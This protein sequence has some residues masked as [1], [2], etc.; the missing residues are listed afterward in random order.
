MCL[1]S[2]SQRS[3]E[4]QTEQDSAPSRVR[5]YRDG[6]EV[7]R[8]LVDAAAPMNTKC[9]RFGLLKGERS[10]PMVNRRPAR[11]AVYRQLF[12]SDA[13]ASPRRSNRL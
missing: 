10:D 8:W 3:R 7:M 4:I 2:V 11:P 6:A 5:G 13:G 12:T 9:V 1:N